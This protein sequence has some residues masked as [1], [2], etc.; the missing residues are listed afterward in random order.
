MHGQRTLLT[1]SYLYAAGPFCTYLYPSFLT[2]L[3]PQAWFLPSFAFNSSPKH[4]IILFPCN[5]EC[6]QYPKSLT[7][8]S[9]KGAQEVNSCWLTLMGFTS[10]LRD[11]WLSWGWLSFP[12]SASFGI[13]LKLCLCAC[14][15]ELLVGQSFCCYECGWSK[16]E[17]C[18]GCAS[19]YFCSVLCPVP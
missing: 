9:L 11:W 6:V 1:C 17:H 3:V 16:T 19:H 12:L 5:P 14:R 18:S 2:M 8:S 10:E 7:L 4:L 13:P 15:G